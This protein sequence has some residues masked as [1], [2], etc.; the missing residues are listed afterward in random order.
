MIIDPRDRDSGHTLARRAR[1]TLS[2]DLDRQFDRFGVGANWQAISRSYDDEDNRN[3][4]G[5]YA[6]LGLRSSW[7]INH[8]VS[9]SLKV[10]NLLD[11]RYARARYSY[12]AADFS[13]NHDYREEGRTWLLGLTWTPHL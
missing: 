12:D 9:V 3:R 4:L 11:R 10:D 7:A 8:D 1:R 5:G 6:L 2:L 13:N